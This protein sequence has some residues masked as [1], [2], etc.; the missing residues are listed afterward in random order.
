MKNGFT[1]IELLVVIAI[2]AVILLIAIPKI[3]EVMVEMKQELYNTQI[4]NIKS[5]AKTWAAD[6]T[7][8][9]P[10]VEDGF[11]TLTLDDLKLGGYVDAEIKNPLTNEFFSDTTE[12]KITRKY[13]EYQYS[14]TPY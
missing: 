7:D 5:G 10:L 14:V 3:N 11:I 12:I 2:L 4:D 9:L 13:N 8:L 1:L 6:N